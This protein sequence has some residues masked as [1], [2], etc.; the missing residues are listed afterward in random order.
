LLRSALFLVSECTVPC[1]EVHQNLF[2]GA[3]SCFEVHHL[4]CFGVHWQNAVFSEDLLQGALCGRSQEQVDSTA[5]FEQQKCGRWITYAPA[6]SNPGTLVFEQEERTA[7]GECGVQKA[8][9]GSTYLLRTWDFRNG[10]FI[11][12]GKIK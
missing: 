10:D 7:V 6:N 12:F 5:P 8:A 1:F 2:Q 3:P 9:S 4:I 11:H